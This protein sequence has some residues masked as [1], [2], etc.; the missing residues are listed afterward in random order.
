[1]MKKFF[2]RIAIAFIVLLITSIPSAF[3]AEGSPESVRSDS[4]RPENPRAEFEERRRAV[5]EMMEAATVWIVVDGEMGINVGS[6]FIVGDGYIATN[7]HVT[8]SLGRKGN[9]YILN[10]KI[11]ARKATLVN[12]I[13]ESKSEDAVSGRDLAILRFEP[14]E[15]AELPILSFNFDVKRMDRVSSWGYPA[16]AARFDISTKP[17][18]GRGDTSK[19]APPPVFYT[20]GTVNAIVR[21]TSGNSILHSASIAGG[22]SGGPLVNSRGEV[23]GMNTWGYT[24]EDE[25]AFLNG[26]Q[27]ASEIALFLADNGVT[28]RLAPGQQIETVRAQQEEMRQGMAR[29]PAAEQK[30][31]LPWQGGQATREERRRDVG[32]F[33]VVVP[34][35]WSVLDEGKNM[36]LLGADDDSSAVG[37]LV[38]TMKGKNLRQAAREISEEFDGTK[39][40]LDDEFYIFT[41]TDDEVETVVLVGEIDED[42]DEFIVIFASGDM[43]NPGV[44]A[45]F[46]SVE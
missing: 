34:R 28:P 26:A 2:R 12:S 46:D 8:D 4:V 5:A 9:F 18:L 38:V 33:S 17:I 14:P 10:E 15:G 30:P 45:I 29:L 27:L 22:N 1:M 37:L 20:E 31:F 44:E 41:Y 19:L 3:A 36:I 13:H 11:P 35:N 7:A 21:D 16:M 42:E 43:D 32:D 23:V 6:G 25:G 39:P 24:E 40:E